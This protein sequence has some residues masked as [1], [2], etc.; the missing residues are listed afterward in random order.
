MAAE[1]LENFLRQGATSLPN[2]VIKG[3]PPD[4]K[5]CAV[6]FVK[7]ELVSFHFA[8][9]DTNGPQFETLNVML[10]NFHFH[11]P[12]LKEQIQEGIDDLDAGRSEPFDAEKIK[13][14]ARRKLLEE[15]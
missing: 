13:A 1:F 15:K 12:D 7:L 4:A 11:F 8:T 2:R 6:E 14:E 5:L 9:A 3:L 10:E